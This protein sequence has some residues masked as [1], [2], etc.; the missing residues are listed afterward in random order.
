[1][2]S[3]FSGV[4]PSEI[5][6]DVL[7]YSA[8]ASSAFSSSSSSSSSY[9]STMVVSSVPTTA[10]DGI[11]ELIKWQIWGSKATD[12]IFRLPVSSVDKP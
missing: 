7:A 8:T 10:F 9:S 12:P 2:R 1:M 11:V 5:V 6:R 3:R 4:S